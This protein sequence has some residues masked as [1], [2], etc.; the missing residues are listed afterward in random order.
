MILEGLLEQKIVEQLSSI[1]SLSGTQFIASRSVDKT[2]DGDSVVAVAAGFR[3]HDSFSLTPVTLPVTFT[4]VT[5]VEEDVEQQKHNTIVEAIADKLSYWHKFGTA[6]QDALTTEKCVANELKMDGGSESTFDDTQRIWTD[7]INISIR[8]AEKF[9]PP[10]DPYVG[11]TWYKYAGSDKL[12]PIEITGEAVELG[13]IISNP[14][15]ITDLSV[16]EKVTSLMGAFSGFFALSNVVIP[17]TITNV[18]AGTFS[19]CSSLLSVEIPDSTLSIG[20]RAFYKCASLQTIVVGSG[21]SAIHNHAFLNVNDEIQ[22]VQFRG[23]TLEQLSI[24]SGYAWALP[25]TNVISAELPSPPLSDC[26]AVYEDG[27]AH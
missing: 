4:I 26:Y 2:E 24:M 1:D 6:M 15:S 12:H 20:D 9:I 25:N 5:K 11:W 27:T 8:G 10:P 16:G 13:L 14:Q 21:V 17:D 23:K 19:E 3:Q 18:G 22:S 7:I